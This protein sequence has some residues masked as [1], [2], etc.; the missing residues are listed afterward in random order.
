MSKVVLI[1]WENRLTKMIHE[2]GG[3]KVVDALERAAENLEAIRGECLVAL[4][5]RLEEIVRLHGEGGDSPAPAGQDGIYQLANEIHGVA[6]VF[7][8][9]EMGEAAFSLCELVDRLR[10]LGRWSAA[11]IAVHISALKLFREPASADDR[12]EVL[13]G[14]K[15]ITE[16][17][18]A[19][20]T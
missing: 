5:Q 8:M 3:V 9:A 11:A 10:A 2:P 7:G 17:Y 1:P 14:L 18:A 16:R 4:E 12:A 19:V 20:R 13:H 6:G 15:L